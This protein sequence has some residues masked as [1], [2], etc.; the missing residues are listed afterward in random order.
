[1]LKNV[2]L[3]GRKRLRFR[4][5]CVLMAFSAVMYCQQVQH[6]YL[7]IHRYAWY[8]KIAVTAENG[9]LKHINMVALFCQ[10]IGNHQ[11]ILCMAQHKVV[12]LIFLLCV[13]LRCHCA[14]SANI[15]KAGIHAHMHTLS[16]CT[17]SML[18]Y[19][20]AHTYFHKDARLFICPAYMY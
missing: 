16:V 6:T 10:V 11:T 4:R 13:V 5:V 8:M 19:I 12:K 9:A 3:N 14:C 17:H 2:Y 1:M 7:R 15:C 20:L 18:T